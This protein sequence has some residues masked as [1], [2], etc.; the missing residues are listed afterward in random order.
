MKLKFCLLFQLVYFTASMAQAFDE[1]TV[2]K[3]VMIFVKDEFND[4]KNF[5]LGIKCPEEENQWY[6]DSLEYSPWFVGDFNDDKIPDLFITGQEKKDQAHYLILGKDELDEES[7][8]TLIPVCPPKNRGNLVIPFIEESRKGLLIL[9]KQFKTET[10]IQ[11]KDGQETRLPR[12]YID[13]YKMGLIKKDTLV[14][15]FGGIIEYNLKPTIKD[16]QFI[17][18]HSFCQFGGCPDFKMKIDS[19]GQMILSNIKNTDEEVGMYAALC[20]ESVFKKVYSLSNYLK[21]QKSN[22]HFGEE[23]ADKTITMIISYSDGTAKTW[24]DYEQGASLGISKLYDLFFEAKKNATWEYKGEL[25][26]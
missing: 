8:F 14:Y 16:I 19:L 26:E 11:V 23:S 17:Q 24:Y 18:M 10:T 15:N 9:F 7:G 22:Q 1:F 21:L 3:E 2:D 20:E 13:Y 5:S 12:T 25:K 4:L 6:L